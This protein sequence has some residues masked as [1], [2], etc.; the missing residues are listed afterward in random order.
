MDKFANLL[1]SVIFSP[2]KNKKILLL[3]RF[4]K[5]TSDPDR[6]YAIAALTGQLN[7]EYIKSNDLKNLVKNRVDPYL[8]DL[9][10]EYVGDMAETIS[11][12]WPGRKKGRLPSI[13]EF[14][15]F[16]SS[17]EKQKGLTYLSDILDKSNQTERWSIIKLLTGGLRIGL[18]E[19]NTKIALSKYG[20]KEIERI[21]KIWHGLNPPYLNLFAWL[22]GIKQEPKIDNLKIF[23]PMM[24]SNPIEEKK[25]FAKMEACNYVAE[26]KW[27][28]IRVQVILDNGKT[29]IFSR[30][31]DNISHSFP[32][33]CF[34]SKV[35]IVLDGELLVGKDCKPASFNELQ[36]R[37]NRKKVSKKYTELYPAFIK[38]YDI[39]FYNK[40]DMRNFPLIERRNVLERW[41]ES[42]AQKKLDLS[43]FIKFTNWKEIR[44]I[45]HNFTELREG[46][47]GLMLKKKTSFYISGRPKGLW[48][49]WKRNPKHVDAILMYAQR[50]HGKRSSYYSDFTFG[51]WNNGKLVPIGKA[52]TGF[53]NEELN[54]LDKFVRTNTINRYGPV[55]EVKKEIVFEVAFDSVTTSKRHK[56]GI[57]L[58]FPRISRIRWDKPTNE[59][60]NLDEILNRISIKN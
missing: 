4:L 1:E 43:E 40:K 46:Y 48:F 33:L 27:D 16:I 22:D 53:T 8:F 17:N 59:V 57:A 49:K 24:L 30:N 60:Q 18:S 58:R 45:K 2:S 21:E 55:R 41:Y 5:Q 39:L 29:T 28:G 51:V 56:S 37:L 11:L 15:C 54:K 32:D 7:F 19:K 9:S 10:Y 20:N 42:N 3:I 34:N 44:Q 6:G 13:E 47:E 36:Q 38:L 23:H 12:I 52:Y 26:W 31:G 14:V 25:D 50:G 35:N